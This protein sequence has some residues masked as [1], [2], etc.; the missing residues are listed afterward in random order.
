MK[1]LWKN[2]NYRHFATKRGQI[3]RGWPIVPCAKCS[4]ECPSFEPERCTHNV[5]IWIKEVQAVVGV[6]K[7]TRSASCVF[8]PRWQHFGAVG[9][10]SSRRAWSRRKCATDV[11]VMAFLTLQGLRRKQFVSEDNSWFW[12]C[13]WRTSFRFFLFIFTWSHVSPWRLLRLGTYLFYS[14]IGK[15]IT[16]IIFV[17]K[18]I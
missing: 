10:P 16:L 5:A 2:C 14:W 1:A 12:C 17:H 15:L 4:M 3:K 7:Q 11:N 13:A 18:E 6:L 9:S 8:T